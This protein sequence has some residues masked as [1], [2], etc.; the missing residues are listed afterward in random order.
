MEHFAGIQLKVVLLLAMSGLLLFGATL[1]YLDPWELVPDPQWLGPTQL[2]Y[3]IRW[4]LWCFPA[5]G[6]ML[7]VGFFFL[8][9][10]L[11]LHWAWWGINLVGF[12]LILVWLLSLEPPVFKG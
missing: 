12:L 7:G 6:E 4:W 9:G 5:L 8:K 2:V 1:A 3:Q 11:G 10:K